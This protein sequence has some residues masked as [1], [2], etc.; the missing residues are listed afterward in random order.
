MKKLFLISI[1]LLSFLGI[2]AQ[3]ELKFSK[4]ITVDSLKK[5]QL[6]IAARSFVAEYYKSSKDV[7]QMDDKN[8]CLLIGQATDEYHATSLICSSYSGW[9]DYGFKIETK[10]GRLRVELNSF[11]H[12]V[13][14]GNYEK[15]NLG[16]LTTAEVF[17]D[18]GLSKKYHNKVW[19]QLKEQAGSI[20]ADFFASLEK[21]VKEFKESKI[22]PEESW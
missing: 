10:D 19:K 2:R 14:P 9:I 6:Y 21:Y 17:T 11:I 13:R 15:S 3:E 16:L 22:K 1:M 18:K 4:V 8:S 5:S 12:H 20:S 7:I